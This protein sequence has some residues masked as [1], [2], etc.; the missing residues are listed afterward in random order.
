MGLS[1][2][3][4]QARHR[5]KLYALWDSFPKIECACGCGE[6]IPPINRRGEPAKYKFRHN[7]GNIETQFKKGH[8]TWNKGIRGD[9]S[10]SYKN[11]N[12]AKPYGSIFTKA[13]KKLIRDRDGNK[14]QRCGTKTN[15]GRALEIHHIDFDKANN[16][17]TNL[18]TLCG[19]CNIYFNFHME[20]SLI[21]FPKRKMLLA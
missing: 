8:K 4:R 13:Y 9:A 16:D 18:I 2:A 3:E 12:G 6:L 5:I 17:P 11:G 7:Q 15:N 14:C 19:K 1:P 20:E 10:S 21:A